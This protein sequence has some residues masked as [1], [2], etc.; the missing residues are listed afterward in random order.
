MF[1]KNFKR[2]VDVKNTFKNVDYEFAHCPK[3]SFM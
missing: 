3:K 2:F 1:T